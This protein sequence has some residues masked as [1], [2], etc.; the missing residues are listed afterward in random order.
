MAVILVV[1]DD[2]HSRI[3][4]AARLKPAY[5]V[6]CA[7]N[8]EEALQLFYQKHVDLIV[9]D[10]MMPVMDGYTLVKELRSNG[11][12]VPVILLTAKTAFEDKRRGFST[13]IDD[14]LTKPVNFEELTW[15]IE[16]LLRRAGINASR[17]ICIGC[18][19]VS[20]E[21]YTVSRFD[22][23]FVAELPKK[24]FELLYRL[25]SYPGQIFTKEQLLTDIWGMETETDDSTVKTH[26]S[27][28]R[29]RFD[30]WQEFEIITVRGLGYKAVIT[31]S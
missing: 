25:L 3:L 26:I 6:L 23:G 13:G 11:Q 7:E 19:T 29:A 5:T 16:A 17:K 20:E 24:E 28:L 30:G 12:N 14:Y 10:V 31:A 8:G 15:H 2:K 1:E 27:R 22:N 4:T 9:A 18:V 21:S